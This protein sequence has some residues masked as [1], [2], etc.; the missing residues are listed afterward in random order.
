MTTWIG[1]SGRGEFR[2]QDDPAP[3]DRWAIKAATRLAKKH[4]P[5]VGLPLVYGVGP[6]CAHMVK[7]LASGAIGRMQ[8]QHLCIGLPS[9]KRPYRQPKRAAPHDFCWPEQPAW[10]ISRVW[11]VL[12]FFETD[13]RVL[14]AIIEAWLARD[15]PV[16]IVGLCDLQTLDEFD[17]LVEQFQLIRED[18]SYREL[19]F[20]II[21]PNR[22]PHAS[23]KILRLL[24]SDAKASPGSAK[25]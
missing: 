14:H 1:I 2:R 4:S 7:E 11:I 12:Q 23:W 19:R 22:I 15:V 25:K 5:K 8:S 21:P 6:G 17:E 24:L 16:H 18:R 3:D 10:P 20:E 13:F 9:P